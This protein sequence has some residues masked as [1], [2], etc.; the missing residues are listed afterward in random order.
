[1]LAKEIKIIQNSRF[2][3]LVVIKEVRYT[4]KTEKARSKMIKMISRLIFSFRICFFSLF[5]Y[6]N[7]VYKSQESLIEYKINKTFEK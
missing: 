1:M 4:M 6:S 2:G 7:F 3:N 5:I